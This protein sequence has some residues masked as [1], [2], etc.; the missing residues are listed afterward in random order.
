MAFV[1][2]AILAELLVLFFVGRLGGRQHRGNFAAQLFNSP[3]HSLV[4]HGFVSTRRRAH[5]GPVEGDS[6]E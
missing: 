6:S 4:A 2:A 1:A 3:V 5:L